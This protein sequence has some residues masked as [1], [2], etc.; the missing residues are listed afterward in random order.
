[1]RSLQLNALPGCASQPRGCTTAARPPA[2]TTPMKK[3]ALALLAVV[4]LG[5]VFTWRSLQPETGDFDVEA[6]AP[7]ARDTL[8]VSEVVRPLATTTAT[9]PPNIVVILADDLGWGDLGVQGSRVIESPNIDA[10]AS[11]GVRLTDFYASAPVCTPSRAGLLT[12]RYPLRTG[13]AS[14]LSA[15][16]D[17]FAR[18]LMRRLSIGAGRLGT[19]DMIGG[20]SVVPGLPLSEITIAEALKERG[21]S[22]F[23]AGKWHLGDFTHYPEYH[24]SRHGFDH[25]FGYNMANDD[26]PVALWRDDQELIDDVGIEQ[27]SHTR[28]FTEAAVAWIR[29]W[30]DRP[31][32]IYLAHKDPH[33][34]FF[35]SA[36]FAGKSAAGP[37]GDAVAELDWS[38]GEV[39]K[40]LREVGVA[41][42]TLVIVTSDNGPWYEGSTGGLRG[43]KGQSYEGGF[44]VPFIAVWPDR[45][46]AG[47]V[48]SLPAMNIDLFPTL[49]AAAG[50][51]PPSDRVVDGIDILPLLAGEPGAAAIAERPLYFF[52]EYDVEA[53]RAG[54]WKYIA[55]ISHYTWPIPIDK[56]D[57]LSGKSANSRDYYPAGGGDPVPTLGTWPL[58]YDMGKDREEAYNVARRHPDVVKQLDGQL[59]TWEQAFHA[60]PRGWKD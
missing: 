28:E 50:L 8:T 20:G 1:M 26:W 6:F 47:T 53:V 48:S 16:D 45:L 17:T 46:P 31:F 9:R 4:A 39:R 49:L 27:S 43:R 34:P 32:F 24:P 30:R 56:N 33:Q 14:V 35:P 18:T 40:A 5:G 41:D 51:A 57:T 36:A 38:V 19:T 13:L 29:K 54:R 15:A 10:L 42:H 12:G 44:R 3:L 11:E 21:Y 7:G 55:D 58:L 59:T 25:F 22:T 23:A 2:C 37:Y 52:H 60:A